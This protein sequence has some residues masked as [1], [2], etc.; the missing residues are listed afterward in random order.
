LQKPNDFYP[1][2]SQICGHQALPISIRDE[3]T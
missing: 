1:D 3:I 2:V